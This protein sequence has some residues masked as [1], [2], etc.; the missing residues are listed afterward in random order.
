M[1]W[2]G[3]HSDEGKSLRPKG[4]QHLV[5]FRLE[6]GLPVWRYQIGSIT[7]EKR[8]LMIYG[9]NT[10]HVRY[11]M[12]GGDARVR[13]GLRPLINFRSHDAFVSHAAV[14]RLRRALAR[15][16]ASRCRIAPS[17]RRCG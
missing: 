7:I 2:L 11:E 3:V 5:E 8:L 17:C 4:T 9:Q 10:V 12:I 15:T 1:V 16:T 13:L 14:G 6:A